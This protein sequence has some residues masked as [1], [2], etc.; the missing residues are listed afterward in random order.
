[1]RLCDV[2]N[3][4]R[5]D[6]IVASSA[7]RLPADEWGGQQ[8]WRCCCQKTALQQTGSN[9]LVPV[10]VAYD[11]VNCDNALSKTFW[12]P[13]VCDN[14]CW[15]GPS[16]R[17]EKCCHCRKSC[18][19]IM[20]CSTWSYTDGRH[21]LLPCII[22]KCLFTTDDNLPYFCCLRP[23]FSIFHLIHLKH[24]CHNTHYTILALVEDHVFHSYT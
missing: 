24:E 22:T 16:I 17:Q 12:C 14:L 18:N 5:C 6:I 23:K 19:N 21:F 8:M 1:M 11:D 4:W 15:R 3:G 10:C 2:H 7:S 9:L 13:A 20:L